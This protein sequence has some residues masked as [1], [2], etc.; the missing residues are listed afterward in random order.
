MTGSLGKNV[1]GTVVGAPEG[2][3]ID[4]A[5]GRLSWTPSAAQ[6]GRVPVSLVAENAAAAVVQDFEVDVS[7]EPAPAQPPEGCGCRTTTAGPGAGLAAALLLFMA[8]WR[9]RTAR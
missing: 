4:A 5:S 2:M 8:G 3:T 6:L 1:G 9:R 7:G